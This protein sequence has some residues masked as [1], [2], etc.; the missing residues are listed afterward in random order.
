MAVGTLYSLFL[1]NLE[2]GVACDGVKCSKLFCIYLV[3]SIFNCHNFALSSTS[4]YT[5][6]HNLT[7]EETILICTTKEKMLRKFTTTAAARAPK[8]IRN[9]S[10]AKLNEKDIAFFERNLSPG[11]VV[12]DE[13]ALT[14]YNND[15]LNQY[16]GSSKL[17]LRPGNT[18]DIAIILRHCNE[19]KIAVTPQ[20]GNTGL[21]GGSVPVFDEVVVSL[22]RMNKVLD[23]DEVSGIVVCEAG[24]V[25]QDLDNW[26]KE[27]GHM[28][29]LDLGA[30]GS[31]HIGGNVATNAGGLRYLRY[32]S[33]HGSVLGMEAVL[34][35]GNILDALSKLRKDNT[36]YDLKQLFIGSEGTLGAIT[37]LAISV[38]RRPL[39]VNTMFLAL[40]DFD[41][42]RKTYSKARE[43]LAEV[44]SACEFADRE[45]LDILFTE[46][47]DIHREPF[48]EKYPFHMLLEVSGSDSDHDREKMDRFLE[49]CME[50][51]MIEDGVVAQDSQQSAALWG[52][53]EDITL[54]LAQAGHIY[55]YDFSLPLEHFYEIVEETRLRLKQVDID[56]VTVGYGHV[57]DSNVHLN[58][59]T[60]GLRGGTPEVMKIIE[61]F[62]YDF[63]REKNGSIS[64]EH[65]LGQMKPDK[66]FHT[67]SQTS[68][69][70]MTDIKSVF[71][72]NGI[73]N[74]YKHLSYHTK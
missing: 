70:V 37:K 15:W 32:G 23:F 48:Q 49:Y 17:A 65:G 25:L 28:V 45:S 74:P 47:S 13:D 41:S 60:P 58:I 42:V 71:D 24:C 12:T 59:C 64:A 21:V 63:V 18:E 11:S 30:K 34:P 39:S 36:G 19:R 8:F 6:E 2:R 72:P 52:L 35:N 29:P 1:I 5:F 62:V 31:C 53:R 68:V 55:K 73:M 50:E 51:G 27:R 14:N 38:P 66:I 4:C 69:D 22:S 56:T 61:P 9:P 57:G 10:F 3:C 67:K 16:H 44:L 7:Y 46:L 40:K 26:L 54:A 20:G 33:L 43:Q